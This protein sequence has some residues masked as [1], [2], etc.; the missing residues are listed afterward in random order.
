MSTDYVFDGRER[1]PYSESAETNPR[2]VYGES[3]LAGE[4]AVA[5][6]T[7]DALVARLSFVWGV[8]RSTG[9]LT[10][11]PAWVRGQLRSGDAIP[12]FTDQWVTPTRAGQAAE[13]LLD[14]IEQEATGLFHVAC[15][16]CVSPYE[17]GEVIA[18]Y[19]GSGEELLTEGSMEDIERVATRPTYSCL[20][21]KHVE[22]TLG[23]SQPTIREDIEAVREAFR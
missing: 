14:L 12:L 11:F 7:T 16:S 8:H 21:I 23:R 4:Q 9:D 19:V 3:K 20:D 1:D 15:S 10:G 13:S 2:Q 17:F 18:E 6:E 5:E 22:S